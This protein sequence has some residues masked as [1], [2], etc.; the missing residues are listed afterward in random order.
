MTIRRD[1]L[2]SFAPIAILAGV[3]IA[4][5]GLARLV[6]LVGTAQDD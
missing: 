5:A 6:Q 3:A 2:L 1:A 4:L